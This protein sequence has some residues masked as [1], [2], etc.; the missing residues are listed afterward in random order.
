M[1]KEKQSDPREKSTR[2]AERVL[3]FKQICQLRSLPSFPLLADALGSFF[4][5]QR[6]NLEWL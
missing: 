1:E 2:W 4:K 3:P 6:L 5:E